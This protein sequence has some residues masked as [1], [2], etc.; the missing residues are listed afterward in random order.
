MATDG[1]PAQPKSILRG[2]KAPSARCNLL[3]KF[4]AEEE[5]GLSK[6]LPL[7]PTSEAR[8]Q[9]WILYMLEVNT[10][11]FCSFSHC[12]VSPGSGAASPEIL[13]TVPNTLASEAIDIF[14][15][16]SQAR[17]HTV[18]LG[19]KNG[20]V[21]ALS[22]FHLG[23]TLTLV[24][25]YENGAATVAQLGDHGNW[26][27]RYHAKCHSQPVLSLDVSPNRDYF[28]TSSAD[29]IIA[30][31]PLPAPSPTIQPPQPN[32]TPSIPPPP[33][34]EKPNNPPTT[35]T[36]PPPPPPPPPKSLLTAALST[37]TSNTPPTPTPPINSNSTQTQPQT[38]TP[39][40]THNT[41]H[42]GQQSLRIRSDGRVFATA[43]WD[44][45]VRVYS[46]R[47]LAEVAVLKWHG[48]GCYAAA[49]AD[50]ATVDGARGEGEG[51]VGNGEGDGDGDG[52]GEGEGEGEGSSQQQQGGQGKE[53]VAV[54]KLVDITVRE[55]RERLA[56]EG[57]WLAAGSKD[58]KVS[59][60]DVF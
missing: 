55:K 7:D 58:G 24:A 35:T 41:R 16:P 42:A 5:S 39:L 12:P 26:A 53:V 50:V 3:W 9:P 29:A 31:H 51:G 37:T 20:M 1:R 22:L 4:T 38:T 14:H 30:K 36:P 32:T 25:G 11:N 18:K 46:A 21:M 56:R 17:Q 49:F 48:V 47:T 43:G 60:W 57:H 59:L 2:H 23:Q 6:K 19:E 52:E 54:P 13:V 34:A 10:M 44:A 33:P 40:K 27:V 45:R 28:L 8:P 15:L